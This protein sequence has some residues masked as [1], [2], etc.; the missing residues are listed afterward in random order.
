MLAS[1]GRG[2]GLSALD[3]EIAWR[4]FSDKREELRPRVL[5]LEDADHGGSDGGGILLLDAAH[6][7]AEMTGFD[8][9]SDALRDDRVLDSVGDL[10]RET[11]L[12]LQ[13]AREDFDEA[14]DFAESDDFA[15]R[16]V[17]DMDL[18]EE[19]Q[20]V[21]LAERIH[22]DILHDDHLVVVHI[23]VRIVQDSVGVL[24]VS[25]GEEGECFFHAL[26]SANETVARGI[27]I[28]AADDFAVDV[29]GGDI[30]K[31]SFA[32]DVFQS[33]ARVVIIFHAGFAFSCGRF[34]GTGYSKELFEVSSTRTAMSSACLN[35]VCS[36]R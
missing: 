5:F 18:S 23:E 7:H 8:D 22:F 19:R 30:F 6:H 25:L 27:S 32:N 34:A 28:D 10:A 4:A 21:M 3:S 36:R 35:A 24:A 33:Y 13:A 16:N 11:L 14:R 15:V 26:G 31:A 29:L 12:H 1:Q 9:D 17:R 20:H 2:S